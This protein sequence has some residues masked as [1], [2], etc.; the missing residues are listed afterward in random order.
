MISWDFHAH[1]PG[2]NYEAVKDLMEQLQDIITKTGY[3]WT[4]EAVAL[5][6]VSPGQ[7]E[8]DASKVS[9]I[10]VPTLLKQQNGC[11]RTNCMDCLDR[12]NVIQSQ[13]AFIVLTNQLLKLGLQLPDYP[14]IHQKFKHMW[15]DNGDDISRCYAGTNAL[16]NDFTRNGQRDITGFAKDAGNSVQRLYLTMVRDEYTQ[17]ILNVIHGLEDSACLFNKR[18]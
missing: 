5:T 16:K 3:L 6:P 2:T 17:R 18:T 11:I 14:E 9:Q 13:I 10:N 8:L 1:C 4:T 12:T 15:A 7:T